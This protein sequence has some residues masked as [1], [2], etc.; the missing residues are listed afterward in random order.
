M[1]SHGMVAVK[2][3]GSQQQPTSPRVVETAKAINILSTDQKDDFLL[4]E[5]QEFLVHGHDVQRAA[6]G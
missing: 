5:P 2:D 1:N 4:V 3:H 6:S